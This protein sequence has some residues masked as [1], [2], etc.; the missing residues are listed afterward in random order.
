ME[1][2]CQLNQPKRCANRH[3]SVHPS[4][5]PLMASTTASFFGFLFHLCCVYQCKCPFAAVVFHSIRFHSIHS[6][7]HSHLPFFVVFSSDAVPSHY[8]MLSELASSSPFHFYSF[9]Q[10]MALA[11]PSA[12]LRVAHPSICASSSS[13]SFIFWVPVFPSWHMPRKHKSPQSGK[14]CLSLLLISHQ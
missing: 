6:F 14:K 3:P 12:L 8:P 9:F 7:I 11:F 2:C 10:S 13:S 4:I 5:S 1:C